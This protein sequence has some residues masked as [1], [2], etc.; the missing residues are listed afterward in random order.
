MFNQQI[1]EAIKSAK[2]FLDS[3]HPVSTKNFKRNQLIE[4]YWQYHQRFK[5]LKTYAAINGNVLDIGSGSGGLQFWKGY[6]LPHRKDTKMTAVDLHKGEFFDRYEHYVL[7]N[8]DEKPLPFAKDS[9]DSIML[10][11][12][13]E[14]VQDWKTLLAQ[15]IKILKKEG[16]IYIETPSKHTLTLP[17]KKYYVE[18]GF[19]CTTINFFDDNTH[20]EPT[21]L[22]EV[23][24]YGK[25]LG[26]MVVEG[27]YCKN[28]YLE[29]ML[30]SYGYEHN[31]I[32]VCQYGIWS[33][34]LFS[35][36]IVMQ[37]M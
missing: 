14:H 23:S 20:V 37:K 11:H 5:L 4:L 29:N 7:Q 19:P 2:A 30:L 1:E 27:G 16:V 34:L 12:L 26:F 6:L 25:E 33:K 15:C 31:D 9:F 28:V 32:E 18:K 35:S 3:F 36:Y 8:L 22:D 17:S 10:S 21:D 13:I 24:R